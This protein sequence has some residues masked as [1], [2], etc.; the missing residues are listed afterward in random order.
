MSSFLDNVGLEGIWGDSYP[1]PTVF[2]SLV[3]LVQD[4][5][6]S[7]EADVGVVER[8]RDFHGHGN[9]PVVVEGEEIMGEGD[10]GMGQDEDEGEERDEESEG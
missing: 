8:F 2:A 10:L 4:A 3:R 7:P 5:C 6:L 1:D 9:R